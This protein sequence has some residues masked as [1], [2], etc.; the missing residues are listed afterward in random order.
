MLYIIILFIL[1]MFIYLY[2]FIFAH[3]SVFVRV[4]L[5]PL[6]LFLVAVFCS[7]MQDDYF[8]LHCNDGYDSFLESVFK[9][10]ILTCLTKSYKSQLNKDLQVN[11]SD[12]SARVSCSLNFMLTFT[13][14]LF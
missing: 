13:F 8:I 5:R 2:Y 9:T 10:E 6:P 7:T 1:Y 14:I 4:V 3:I 11:F 12:R